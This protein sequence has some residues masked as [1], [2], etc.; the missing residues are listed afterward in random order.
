MTQA[1]VL[2]ALPDK[3]VPPARPLTYL[4][5]RGLTKCGVC[6]WNMEGKRSSRKVSGYACSNKKCR[7]TRIVKDY[8]ED[9]LGV[10][11]L[12]RIAHPESVPLLAAAMSA[13]APTGRAIAVEIGELEDELRELGRDLG[14]GRIDRL[15]AQEAQAGYVER[16]RALRDQ[17]AVY[18]AFAPLRE[19]KTPEQLE[20][21]WSETSTIEQRRAVLDVLID[22]IRIMPAIRLGFHNFDERRVEIV[23][24]A[25]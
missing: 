24:S 7:K 20:Q 14:A 25:G 16:L 19:L 22:E 4:A 13:S 6:S 8:L 10:Q 18:A 23:W 21:W 12:A 15:V 9:Y 11:V 2:T 17:A 3:P 1:A 5:T